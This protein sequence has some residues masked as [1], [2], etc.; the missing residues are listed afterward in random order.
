M[1]VSLREFKDERVVI[2]FKPGHQ[3][4]GVR[5]DSGRV[6]PFAV[7]DDKG[8]HSFS[9]TPVLQGVVVERGDSMRVKISDDTKPPGEAVQFMEVKIDD[10]TIDF[11]TVL[12][13]DRLLLPS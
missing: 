2:Q 7:K 3:W 11:V 13:S 4:I 9:M 1:G 6:A 10:D 12:S 5:V 8:K